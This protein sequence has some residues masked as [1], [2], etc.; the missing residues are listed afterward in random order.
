MSRMG[1]SM[2]LVLHVA[3]AGMNRAE[4]YIVMNLILLGLLM[5]CIAEH[6]KSL[7]AGGTQMHC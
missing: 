6:G 3:M 1:I 4:T 5:K 7:R 2:K